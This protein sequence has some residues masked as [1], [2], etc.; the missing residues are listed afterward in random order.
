MKKIL[1]TKENYPW[2]YSRLDRIFSHEKIIAWFSYDCGMNKRFKPKRPQEWPR[3]GGKYIINIAGV[4][5]VKFHGD[6]HPRY[7]IDTGIGAET[8]VIGDVVCFLG[9]RV[10]IKRKHF[11]R[12]YKEPIYEYSCYQIY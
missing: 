5:R 3:R 8:I 12:Y 4:K 6:N 2:V 9:N 1:I 7:Y 11:P 10:I